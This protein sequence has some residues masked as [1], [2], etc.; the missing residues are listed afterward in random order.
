MGSPVRAWIYGHTHNVSTGMINNTFVAVN[1]RGYPNQIID[2][3]SSTAV[4]EFD[5]DPETQ[6]EIN[7]ELAAAAAGIRPPSSLCADE[8]VEMM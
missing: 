8:M 1:A 2:G 7:S 3:F 5:I 6:V 4:V